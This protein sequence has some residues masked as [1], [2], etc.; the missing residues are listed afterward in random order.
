MV[1]GRGDG[2]RDAGGGDA[3]SDAGRRF[4]HERDGRPR[5]VSP[6]LRPDGREAFRDLPAYLWRATGRGGRVAGSVCDRVAP[7][8]RLSA[9][10]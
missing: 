3:K 10:A 9:G 2:E 4:D 6:R 8:R 1:E 7:C 5:G